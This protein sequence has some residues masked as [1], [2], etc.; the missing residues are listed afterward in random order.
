M[1]LWVVRL[2][3]H[4]YPITIHL[5]TPNGLFLYSII[6]FNEIFLY[7]KCIIFYHGLLFH[8]RSS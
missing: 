6:I 1:S 8:D 2:K 5:T 4:S 3:I 7:D